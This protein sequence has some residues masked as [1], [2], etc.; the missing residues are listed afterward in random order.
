[1]RRT[2]EQSPHEFAEALRGGSGRGHLVRDGESL[3]Y[4]ASHDA[5]EDLAAALNGGIPGC[6]GHEAVFFQVGPES[7]ALFSAFVHNT[8][9]GQ[10][11]GGLRHWPYESMGDLMRDGLRLSRA[12]TRKCALAG[13]WWGGGKGIIARAPGERFRDP[14]YRRLL[15]REY[16]AFV[17]SLR[18][19]YITAEDAGTSPV[20]IAEVFSTTRFATSIPLEV[21]GVGNPSPFTA[22]GVVCAME[23]ALEATLGGTLEGRTI[24]MQGAGNVGSSMVP[25]LLERGVARIVVSEICADQ[26]AALT[27]AFEGQPV[28]VRLAD[29][30][31]ASILAEA[32]DVLAPNALGGTLGPKTI[33]SIR[34]SI[35]C[36]AANNQLL[37]EERDAKALVER[38]IVYVPDFLANRMG[39]VACANEQYGSVNDDAMMQRHLDRSWPGS[40]HATVLQVLQS[41]RDT[42]ESPVVAATA[43]ADER[44]R[45]PHPIWGH[46][47]HEIIRSLVDDRWY[48]G[49][50]PKE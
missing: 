39:I 10:A 33:G 30:G 1:M 24:A 28:D 4:R 49:S 16:G 12:M 41:A 29:P 36:G 38:G 50:G 14:D 23:A 18:G 22:A 35:V 20:D 44:A 31:D 5:L 47:S 2:L 11:Q 21:G 8:V 45:E 6:A 37:D 9:R 17:S 48:K 43:L 32:C 27:S 15:Y 42:G 26:R 7:G 34:A 46:R 13:L 40:I 25:L 19:C 3:T